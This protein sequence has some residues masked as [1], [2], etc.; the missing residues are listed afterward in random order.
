MV[1]Y[2][3]PRIVGNESQHM[4]SLIQWQRWK[5]ISCHHKVSGEAPIRI[6]VGMKWNAWTVMTSTK[7][8]FHMVPHIPRQSFDKVTHLPSGES[9]AVKRRLTE[10]LHLEEPYGS[11]CWASPQFIAGLMLLHAFGDLGCKMFWGKSTETNWKISA[12]KT[13]NQV[14]VQPVRRMS[15]ESSK[16]TT[17]P[18]AWRKMN[19]T[20]EAASRETY[21]T[22]SHLWKRKIIGTQLSFK[23]DM[24]GYFRS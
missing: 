24:Y 22:I 23:W 6:L 15:L 19:K 8:G 1:I 16:L 10:W 2:E 17:H 18:V 9:W 11:I 21:P 20:D 14:N 5:R 4:E 3:S 13:W 12:R 7:I